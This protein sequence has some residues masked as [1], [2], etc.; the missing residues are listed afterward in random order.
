MGEAVSLKEIK[1]KL[2]ALKRGGKRIVFTN[3]CFDIIHAGHVRYLKESK[4]L[5]DILVVGLNSDV[6]V[7]AIKGSK[8]PVF[9]QEERIEVLSALNSTDYIFLFDEP[10]PI[11]LI[12]AVMP[13]ILVKGEDWE[14]EDIVGGDIVKGRGGK[15]IRVP[16]VEGL[17]TTEVIKRIVGLYAREDH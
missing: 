9:T 1:E 7:R 16:M 10:T 11:R 3:G 15:V 14:E 6:S 13:D 5:G 17:S 2:S 12:E 8:R 4:S